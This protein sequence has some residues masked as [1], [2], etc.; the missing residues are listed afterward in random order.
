MSERT[1]KVESPHM[2]GA[3]VKAWQEWLRMTFQR[4]DIDY[5]IALDGDYGVATRAATASVC[6]ALGLAAPYGM[7]D[8]VTPE[9]RTK[10]RHR[11]LTVAER[12]RYLGSRRKYRAA[13]RKRFAAGGHVHTP[14]SRI[15]TDAW[16]WH[17]GVHDGIDLICPP[18]ATLYAICDGVIVR[19]DAGGW[20]GLGAPS[21]P[22]VRAKGDGI[23]VLRS[24]TAAG[25]FR[26]GLHFC[27]G[28]AEH[29]TVRE[30]QRVNAGDV[31]GKAGLANAWHTHFM[32]NGRSDAKGVGDRDPRPFVDYAR[33]HS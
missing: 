9:L 31:I 12:T 32:V 27:Y 26:A 21:D 18:N 28:H 10:L 30:G 4:W 33:A 8:G 5:P 15:I 20:W 24:E 1:F 3:D 25:P 6:E 13:L 2:S 23:I 17:P 22:A 11:R 16:G 14:V 7:A 19:A 29:A